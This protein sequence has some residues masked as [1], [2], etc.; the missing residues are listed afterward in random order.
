MMVPSSNDAV[1]TPKEEIVALQVIKMDSNKKQTGMGVDGE[2]EII[3]P[4][5]TTETVITTTVKN[6]VE[7]V[8]IEHVAQIRSLV[9]G[10]IKTSVHLRNMYTKFN[11]GDASVNTI[12]RDQFE[13]LVVRII[14]KANKGKHDVDN[15]LLLLKDEIWMSVVEEGNKKGNKKVKTVGFVE[16]EKWLFPV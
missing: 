6:V 12:S 15:D 1:D 3:E 13:M 10:G 14:K 7:D 9:V 5:T 8:D 2:I 4:L 16:L 11:N